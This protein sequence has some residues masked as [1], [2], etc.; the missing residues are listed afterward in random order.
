MAITI[1][2][3]QFNRPVKDSISD[4][5]TISKSASRIFMVRTTDKED[6]VAILNL[7][8]I[9]QLNDL[10]PYDAS[11]LVSSRSVDP[12]VEADT[13]K[14]TVEYA[15]RIVNVPFDKNTKPWD[16]PP[17]NVS[18]GSVPYNKVMTKAY[19]DGD[20]KDNPSV[21]ILNTAGDPFDPPLEYVEYNSLIKFTYNKKNFSLFDIKKYKRTINAS[22]EII[23]DQNIEPKTAK[24]NE[25][26][27]VKV[28]VKDENGNFDYSYYKISIVMEIGNFETKLLNDGFYAVEN[29]QKFEI[30]L[31][32]DTGNYGK[33]KGD[34]VTEPVKLDEN[35]AILPQGD[36]PVYLPFQTYFAQ[37][38]KGL[39]LPEKL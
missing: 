33:D 39:G 35:G 4:N 17:Y 16:L 21:D 36:S 8:G 30:K 3:E 5:S 1:L 6:G 38:W 37:N 32:N 20:S 10:H 11:L 9:P 26:D 29:G 34:P 24:I 27:A 22:S 23:L 15:S 2:G 7:E 31:D 14:V 28:D 25:I 13:W 19:K 18:S 12:D